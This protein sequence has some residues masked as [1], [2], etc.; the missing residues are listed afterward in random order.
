VHCDMSS[1]SIRICAAPHSLS[2]CSTVMQSTALFAS[3]RTVAFAHSIVM[4]AWYIS[5]R[6]SVMTCAEQR[7]R[8]STLLHSCL[9]IMIGKTCS[10]E[11][12]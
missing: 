9:H 12:A 4:M 1:T 11:I 5:M 8:V 10:Q 3:T 2:S 6:S 7:K